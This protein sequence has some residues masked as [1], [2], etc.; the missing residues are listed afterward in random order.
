MSCNTLKTGFGLDACE[1]HVSML[2]SSHPSHPSLYFPQ[3]EKEKAT[4]FCAG[5][6]QGLAASQGRAGTTWPSLAAEQSALKLPRRVRDPLGG[7]VPLPGPEKDPPGAREPG[8]GTGQGAVQSWIASNANL[9]EEVEHYSHCRGK[10][11]VP[12]KKPHARPEGSVTV[13]PLWW[14]LHALEARPQRPRGSCWV[15]PAAGPCSERQPQGLLPCPGG[16]VGNEPLADLIRA[17][18]GGSPGR[19][20]QGIFHLLAL[21]TLSLSITDQTSLCFLLHCG[22]DVSNRKSL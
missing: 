16:A 2:R 5:L 17:T 1:L 11:G 7:A 12:H 4:D 13:A 8:P 3:G 18:P 14:L 22:M 19:L 15:L 21:K 6:A 10:D 20:Q 9:W